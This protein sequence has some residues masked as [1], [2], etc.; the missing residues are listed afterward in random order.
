MRIHAR[1]EQHEL[2]VARDEE[3]DHLAVAVARGQALAHQHAQILRQRRIGVV[4]RLVLADH[5][6]QLLRQRAGARFERG[7]FQD[8]VGLHG[9]RGRAQRQRQ[10]DD[11]EAAHAPYS[12]GCSVGFCR[13]GFGAPT[14]RR[15]SESE[16]APPSTI[17][18]QPN[19][20]SSTSGL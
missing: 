9:E 15:R 14:R 6:A 16:S 3:V 13:A 10:Q 8:L 7:V 1:P 5:A 17:T 19:Q 11:R 4:D 2:A 18:T 12:A 20:I